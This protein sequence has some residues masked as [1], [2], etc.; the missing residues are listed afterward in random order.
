[1]KKLHCLITYKNVRTSCNFNQSILNW[2]SAKNPSN[3]GLHTHV[4]HTKHLLLLILCTTSELGACVWLS[5]KCGLVALSGDGLMCPGSRVMYQGGWP[6][7][8]KVA[9]V[10]TCP[11]IALYPLT[12]FGLLYTF[13]ACMGILIII[14]INI[15]S[16]WGN[17]LC[18]NFITV[19]Q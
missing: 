7:S 2:T 6:G 8:L 15:L 10:Y 9:M 18:L 13:I 14:I 12:T 1:M 17:C 11:C 16:C 4:H 5:G 19:I 3:G